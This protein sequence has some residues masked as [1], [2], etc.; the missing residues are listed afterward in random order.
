MIPELLILFL[1]IVL[2]S[3]VALAL[4]SGSGKSPAS[5]KS[6]STHSCPDCGLRIPPEEARCLRCGWGL[7]AEEPRAQRVLQQLQRH[8]ELLSKRQLLSP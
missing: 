4:R 7:A 6:H 2:V 8:L 3:T 1:I 5:G